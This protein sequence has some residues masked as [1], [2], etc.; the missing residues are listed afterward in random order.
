MK[1]FLIVAITILLLLPI[2]FGMTASAQP[3]YQGTNFTYNYNAND[4]AVATRPG[5]SP[6]DVISGVTLGAGEFDLPTALFANRAE[7][8]LY[9]LDAGNHRIVVLNNDL[10]L[11]RII[12]PTL[13]G[14]PHE[15]GRMTAGAIQRPGM[16]VDTD[17]TILVADPVLRHVAIM[18][19]QG[20]ISDFIEAP[21]SAEFDIR[22]HEYRPIDVLRDAGGTTFVLSPGDLNGIMQFNSNLDFEGYFGAARVNMTWEIMRTQLLRTILPPGARE[23][24][25]DFSP[26]AY[27]SMHMRDGFIYATRHAEAGNPPGEILRINPVGDNVLFF[28][29]RG[30]QQQ[31][32]I[33]D[34]FTPL[35]REPEVR[36][37]FVD[38]VGDDLGFILALDARQ[39]KIK[40]FDGNSNLLFKW[41][42]I[43]NQEGT[44][45]TPVSIE[46]VGT[47]V[48]VLDIETGNI[49]VFERNS[50]GELFHSAI[51]YT[52][53]HQMD[54]AYEAWNSVLRHDSS[55]VVANIG[56]GRAL[57]EMGEYS[58]AREHLRL[59]GNQGRLD[60]SRALFFVRR[61]TMQNLFPLLLTVLILAIGAYFILPRILRKYKKDEY[62]TSVGKWRYPFYV[63]TH[64]FKGV[65][66]LRDDKKGSLLIANIIL[67]VVFI[68][69][70]ISQLGQGF[71]FNSTNIDEFNI[72]FAVFATFGLF[73]FFV[74]AQWGVSVLLNG[75]GSF[76]DSWIFAAYALMPYALLTIPYVLLTNIMV[77]EDAAMLSLF[78]AI[79]IFI[80]TAWGLVRGMME[81]QQFT[82]MKTLGCLLLVG[83]GMLFVMLI[84]AIAASMIGQL[85]EFI[86]SIYSELTFRT[87]FGGQLMVGVALAVALVLVGLFISTK[88]RATRKHKKIG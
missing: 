7:G 6:V 56:M 71:L 73:A 36:S 88:V 58:Q 27:T 86:F 53:R 46:S 19:S 1:R 34:P 15:F 33:R 12:Y 50:F 79:F 63:M 69:Y 43:G 3:F 47:R 29:Q 11:N 5:Y 74:I 62:S 8:Y 78:Y 24:L 44:F 65:A 51:E 23:S 38:V 37:R 2:I 80:W 87:Q 52:S 25:P 72:F 82:F 26:P 75:E 64:P 22:E 76:K 14:R 4:I 16:F 84:M 28:N 20:A 21:E 18:D 60:Y 39:G 32:G 30:V 45:R 35:T 68:V 41:G 42:G 31:F 66:N 77:I 49:T 55:N 40:Q 81:A 13:D 67:T 70:V 17:G 48:F 9:V 59:A 85:I 61:D 83:F 10:T 54:L 57:L